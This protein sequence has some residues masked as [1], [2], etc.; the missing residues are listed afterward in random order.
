[1]MYF[2][3]IETGTSISNDDGACRWM[4]STM[5]LGVPRIR[6]ETTFFDGAGD[7]A[8]PLLRRFLEMCLLP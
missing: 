5:A 3:Y 7:F 6:L 8:R 4:L 1:M 2:I